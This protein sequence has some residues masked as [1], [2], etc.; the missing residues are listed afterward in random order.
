MREVKRRE[1]A[2]RP[3][4]RVQNLQKARRQLKGGLEGLPR[5][6]RTFDAFRNPL[7]VLSFLMKPKCKKCPK[8][9]PEGGNAG[10]KTSMC[11]PLP[12]PGS[13]WF[14][15]SNEDKPE[16]KTRCGPEHHETCP[17]V[18]FACNTIA[19]K[20]ELTFN[21]LAIAHQHGHVLGPPLACMNL[22][23]LRG[24]SKALLVG[25]VA[26]SQLHRPLGEIGL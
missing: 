1:P 3:R 18:G 7:P 12:C 20:S 26:W 10:E 25:S 17:L 5:K 24:C 8:L 14:E 9:R 13:R 16:R 21:I 11:S 22:E 2:R 23:C 19:R 6:T 4:R 15:T